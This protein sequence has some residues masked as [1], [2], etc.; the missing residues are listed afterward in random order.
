MAHVTRIG[1]SSH[2]T[3]QSDKTAQALAASGLDY[4]MFG[5]QCPYH[6]R[7]ERHAKILAST[8]YAKYVY[9]TSNRTETIWQNGNGPVVC[10]R[11]GKIKVY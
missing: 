7:I 2:I 10:V 8:K 9:E 11:N 4:R 3:N 6:A 5:R 1:N